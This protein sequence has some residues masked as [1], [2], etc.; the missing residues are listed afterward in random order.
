M[1][2]FL[3]IDFK[4]AFDAITYQRVQG[5]FLN[6]LRLNEAVT[7]WLTELT[8]HNGRLPQGAPSSPLIFNLAADGLDKILLTYCREC[9]YGYT[10][11]CDEIVVSSAQPISKE[12]RSEIVQFCRQAGF[13]MAPE[14]VR[15]QESRWGVLEVNK[16]LVRG[17]GSLGLSNR[18]VVD[19]IRA[20]AHRLSLGGKVDARSVAGKIGWVKCVDPDKLKTRLRDCE[21][22][23]T[24]L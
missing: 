13:K 17:D 2:Y 14:K 11:Y 15:Y 1:Y 12:R 20:M 5:I 21:Q 7:F 19:N 4:N 18:K 8:T 9:G 23:I 16:V 24:P 22:F 3:T 10:R 6:Q